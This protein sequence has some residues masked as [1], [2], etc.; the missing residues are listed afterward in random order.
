MILEIADLRP[1]AENME[2]FEA[3]MAELVPVISATPGYIGHSVQ[4]SIETPGRYVLIVQWESVDA[5]MVNFR[6]SELFERWRDRI[7]PYREGAFVEH[8]EQVLEHP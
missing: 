2:D 7:A 4:R 3:A 5:H 6:Q 1:G 8:F